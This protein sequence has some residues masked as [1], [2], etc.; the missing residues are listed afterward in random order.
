MEKLN[1]YCDIDSTVNNHWVRAKNHYG[2]SLFTER[3]VIMQDSP[4][5]GARE[6]LW[7]YSDRYNIH[8]LTAR[9]YFQAYSI[10]KDW[11]I[12]NDFPI[13][14]INVVNSSAEKVPFLIKNKVDLF[15]DD[16]SADQKNHGSYVIL[17]HDT[18]KKLKLNN[19]PYF[20][21]KGS[22]EEAKKELENVWSE[23]IS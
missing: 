18:I 20:R 16:L 12:D 6:V 14:T 13:D 22:W 5:P 19:I 10:T 23:S 17:Y 8:Y 1:L 11:L 7:E 9:P 4:L 3:Y 21:F 15:I 2:T